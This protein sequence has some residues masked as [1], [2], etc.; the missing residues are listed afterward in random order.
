MK[1]NDSKRVIIILIVY[2][3]ILG[4]IASGTL[5]Y[6]NWENSD[7]QRTIVE[8]TLRKDFSCFATVS[9]SIEPSN[10]LLAPTTCT[11]STHAIKRQIDLTAELYGELDV[12]MDLWLEI[13][14][15]DSELAATSNF[16]YALTTN[17][18][19]CTTGVVTSG[20][21]NGLSAGDTIDFFVQRQYTQTTT[22]IYYLYVWLDAAETSTNVMNKTFRLSINGMCENSELE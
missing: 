8:F 10:V 4:C 1:K 6:L 18:N 21:F 15:I 12:Y 11:N 14:S 17:A 7:D 5:A 20:T 9:G 19:S 2:A 16:K 13:N 22:D 3:L